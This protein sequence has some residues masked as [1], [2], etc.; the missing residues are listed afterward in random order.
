MANA[1]TM[2][3]QQ[4]WNCDRAGDLLGKRR[5]KQKREPTQ[6]LEGCSAKDEP[7]LPLHGVKEKET[8]IL[9]PPEAEVAT[10]AKFDETKVW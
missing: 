7:S 10:V 9:P 2:R 5:N 4:Q 6:R 3:H 1:A 8:I